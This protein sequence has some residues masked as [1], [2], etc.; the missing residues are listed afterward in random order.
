MEPLQLIHRSLV[1]CGDTIIAN[2][3]LLDL[4]RRVACFGLSLAKLD[5]RQESDRHTEAMDAITGYIGLGSYS[6][7]SEAKKQEFLL[8]ELRNRRPLLP[9][10]FSFKGIND[11]VHEVLMTFRIC[12]LIG[13]ESLGAY[14]ISMARLPSDV[15]CVELLQK[16]VGAAKHQRVV[17]LFETK[18][19]LERAP[20]T[21]QQLLNVDWYLEHINGMQEVML[22]YSD[23]AKD[24]GRI[25][26]VWSLYTAQE[27]LV[28][29]CEA[30][31]VKLQLF[32]GR[33]G[34]VGRGG[35]PQHIAILSQPPGSL[36]GGMRVTIQGE[37]I[38]SHF[39][40]EG[41]AEQTLERY[42]TATLIATMAP[43]KEPKEEWRA[44]MDQLSESY[45][46]ASPFK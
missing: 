25:T 41:T 9:V 17:P 16:E 38:E 2:G 30:K 35:G 23:S 6:A 43:E 27:Q 1:H 10:N 29:V 44:M 33:G 7:W 24:A 19:D 21:V 4:I 40:L 5:I 34:T 12:A 37:T 39:G 22:G 46:I 14:I 18:A 42:T 8:A 28:K 31:K 15:L 36:R 11:K 20:E 45:S 3:R 32:H 13:T 26:S